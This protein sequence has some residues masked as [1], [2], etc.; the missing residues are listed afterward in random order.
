MLA[1]FTE[2][3]NTLKMLVVRPGL[4]QQKWVD[5]LQLVFNCLALAGPCLVG[6]RQ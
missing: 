4:Q 1:H 6:K 5:V 3:W 2:H